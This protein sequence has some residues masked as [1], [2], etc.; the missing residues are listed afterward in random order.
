MSQISRKFLPEPNIPGVTEQNQCAFALTDALATTP[1]IPFTE[2]A[3]GR[4]YIPSGSSITALT[5]Y[6]APVPGGTF[7]PSYD[8]AATPAAIAWTGLTAG[9]SYLIPPKLFGA[10]AIKIVVNVAGTVYIS[11]KG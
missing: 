1:E 2:F 5:F 6:D 4:I 3:G 10:G 7:L 9:R 8:D 11:R